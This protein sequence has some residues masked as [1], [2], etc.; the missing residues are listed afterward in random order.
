MMHGAGLDPDQR[1]AWYAIHSKSMAERLAADALTRKG[2]ET[3]L[4]MSTLRVRHARR[5]QIVSRPLFRRYLFVGLPAGREPFAEVRKTWG[6]EWLVTNVD[7][8]VRIA[9][10]AIEAIRAAETDGAFDATKPKPEAR[11]KPGDQVQATEGPFCDLVA[12]IVSLPTDRRAEVLLRMLGQQVRVTMP[13]AML[14][15]VA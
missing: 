11:F 14:R 5:T 1:T 8:P 15:N 9:A 10:S 4:P 12:E 3:Y 13:L 6:V 7:K 2:F